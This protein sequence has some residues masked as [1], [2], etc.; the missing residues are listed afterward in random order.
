[1]KT[2]NSSRLGQSADAFTLIEL[3][4]VVA[5]VAILA[6]LLLP[7]LSRG[8]ESTKRTVCISNLR[9]CG[10]ALSFYGEIYRQYPHQRNPGTGNPYLTGDVVWAP[11]GQYVAHEWD[12]VVRLG[13]QPHY[14]A[15][16][17]SEP[18]GRLR[19]FSCPE[20][21][22][23]VPNHAPD[24]RGTDPY[25]FA[26]NY[27]YVGGASQWWNYNAVTDPALSPIKPDDNPTWTLM[28]DIVRYDD[29]ANPAIQHP[30]WWAT[31]HKENGVLPAGA[32]HLFNDG[33][34]SWIKWNGGSNMRTNAA[35][36]ESYIWRRSI[37]T[38]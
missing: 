31:A 22:D 37:G 29:P 34:V 32:N 7:S 38:P 33:H 2:T 10:I 4:V 15:R 28:T 30:G 11:L 8:K 19:I 18:D 12:E 35:W 9:Q 14:Q 3:L 26:M 6:A 27:Y 24:P 5:I 21:G 13:V 20:L 36:V 23:P 17:A 1:M 25:I 16:D